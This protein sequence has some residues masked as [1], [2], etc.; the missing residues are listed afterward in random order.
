[1]RAWLVWAGAVALMGLVVGCDGGEGE[2]AGIL[3]PDT[4]MMGTDSGPMMGVD[5]G[6]GGDS[7]MMM[8][9]DSGPGTDS[10]MMMGTDSGPPPGGDCSAPMLSSGCGPQAVV[11]VRAVL[12]AGMGSMT[13]NLVAN[14]H[15]LYLGGGVTGGFFHT[16]GTR[17]GATIS[18]STAAEV[19]FD[20]CA[21]GEMWSEENCGYNLWVYLD[22]NGNSALDSGEPAGRIE[23][24]VNC[25]DSAAGCHNVVLDCTSGMSCA[26]FADPGTCFCSSP[27]C[28]SVRGDPL[29]RIITCT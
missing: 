29:D 9:T 26:A 18:E 1:M 16:N 21:G 7:G 10:G 25:H 12:G 11:R 28:D 3:R 2:D 23:M 13:G 22:R 8:G 6:P 4:G 19:H 17:T 5:S 15:H 24:E 20:L 14:L 27:N